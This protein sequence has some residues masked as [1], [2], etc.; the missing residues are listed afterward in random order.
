MNHARFIRLV[1]GET[2]AS[3]TQVFE[4][5]SEVALE[6]MI[7]PTVEAQFNVIALAVEMES[8]VLFG[9]GKALTV[10]TNGPKAGE[11][12]DEIS[13]PAGG[14]VVWAQE[15]LTPNPFT[16]DITSFFVTNE[17]PTLP[18]DLTIRILQKTFVEPGP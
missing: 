5:D 9:G 8:I 7:D 10:C 12:T 13:V 11:H 14:M 6:A 15:D 17:D 16:Q 18:A 3:V 1:S 4:G 2:D